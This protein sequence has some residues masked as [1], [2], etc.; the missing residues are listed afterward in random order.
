MKEINNMPELKNYSFYKY[1]IEN[2][3]DFNTALKIFNHLKNFR[4]SDGTALTPQQIAGIMANATVESAFNQNAKSKGGNYHGIWQNSSK[5]K[6]YVEKTYGGYSLEHQLQFLDDWL[7]HEN[8]YGMNGFAWKGYNGTAYKAK[9]H[10][11]PENSSDMFQN[12]YERND[13]V[14]RDK[15]RNYAREWY[16]YIIDSTKA[17]DNSE[18]EEQPPVQQD[19]SFQQKGGT[20]L[21]TIEIKLGKKAYIVKVAET[22]TQLRKGLMGVTNL[23][24]D[25]GMLFDF[26]EEGNHE[27]WM[28]NTQIPLDQIFINS[29]QVVTKVVT[30]EPNDE[31]LIGE[32]ETLY[33]VELN[34]DSG[35]KEGDELEFLD[36]DKEYVMKVLAPDGSV[37]MG[38]KGGERIF[39]R[40]NTKVLIR[41]AKKAYQSKTD[42]DYKRLGKS[43]FKFLSK[44][45]SNEPEYVQVPNSKEDN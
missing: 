22:P 36:D 39:S 2:G 7:N 23:D 16:N 40:A 25:K 6:R 9:N 41:Q 19:I 31:E 43:L 44:Q 12:L 32:P 10:D 33:V 45:D 20:N 35:V 42:S 17:E 38:L 28:Y 37:Q 34:A 11:T 13:G 21:K 3:N 1:I 5:I 30:R 15:R 27:M 24:E 4:F 29:D 26:G 18:L 14:G 8:K